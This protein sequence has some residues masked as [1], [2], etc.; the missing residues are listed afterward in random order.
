[1]KKVAIALGFKG[2]LYDNVIKAQDILDEDMGIN[3]MSKDHT[4]PH[5]TTIAGKAKDIEKI[6]KALNKIRIK[7]FKLKSPGMGIF[8]NQYPN[9]YIRWEQF[10]KPWMVF[11]SYFSRTVYILILTTFLIFIFKN[12]DIWKKSF[13]EIFKKILYFFLFDYFFIMFCRVYLIFLPTFSDIYDPQYYSF[14]NGM[15]FIEKFSYLSFRYNSGMSHTP[16]FFIVIC[17]YFIFIS[18]KIIRRK[19]INNN[20]SKP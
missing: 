16:L 6:Y 3:H 18:I 11:D 2:K 8:A 7:K 12:F 13:P 4:L 5:I 1:M 9:L 10:R 17:I 15:S 20:P 14:Y 19:F